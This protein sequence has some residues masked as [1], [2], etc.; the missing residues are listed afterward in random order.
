MESYVFFEGLASMWEPEAN[1][2]WLAW[3]CRCRKDNLESYEMAGMLEN[4]SSDGLLTQNH[5]QKEKQ[6][7]EICRLKTSQ[8]Y[9]LKNVRKYNTIDNVNKWPKYTNK[10]DYK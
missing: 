10:S 8:A 7:S 6:T 9:G 1:V 5:S 3:L 4:K 2:I